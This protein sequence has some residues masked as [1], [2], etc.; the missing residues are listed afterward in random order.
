MCDC[1]DCLGNV[2]WFIFVGLISGTFYFL[3][4]I[5]CCITIVGIPVGLVAF[6]LSTLCFCPFGKEVIVDANGS[7][8]CLNFLWLLLF[9]WLIPVILAL[10][11]V[12]FCITIIGIPFGLQ[13]FKLAKLSFLPAGARIVTKE[14][15]D[16]EMS[17][18]PQP[19]TVVYVAVP[20]GQ[21]AVIS[22]ANYPNGPITPN[23]VS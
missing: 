12:F 7:N 17:H 14:E 3:I 23:Y 18:A 19:P 16:R 15:Y 9:G 10:D 22:N 8:C 20:E 11:G 6:K 1:C 21:A 5:L 4:G 13:C 2:I